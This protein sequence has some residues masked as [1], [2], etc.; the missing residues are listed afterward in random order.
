VRMILAALIIVSFC[1]FCSLTTWAQDQAQTPTTAAPPV[2]NQNPAPAA[3]PNPAPDTAKPAA[4]SPSPSL[5]NQPADTMP[6]KY[7]EVWN[8]GNFDHL[9]SIFSPPISMVSH[10]NRILLKPEILKTVVTAWRKAMPDL[11]FKIEDTVIQGDYVVMRLTFKGT[12]KERLFP[13]TAAPTPDN[14]RI[15]HATEMLM[16]RLKDGKIHSIWEEYD[17]MRM[18]FQMGGSWRTD[19]EVKAAATAGA[20]SSKPAPDEAQP[21]P[22]EAQ[23]AATPPKP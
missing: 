11:T 15:V 8:T 21:A 4:P 1:S 5:E 7:V 13:N 10:G 23:P 6:R 2:P 19:A 9:L 18:R 22:D 3:A 14:P 16:F 20:G 12:Y 17:E